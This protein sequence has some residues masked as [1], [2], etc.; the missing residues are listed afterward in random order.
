[1]WLAISISCYGIEHFRSSCNNYSTSIVE[2]AMI[3]LFKKIQQVPFEELFN[4]CENSK[5]KTKFLFLMNKAENELQ[6][7][8]ATVQF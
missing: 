7:V 3:V 2:I 4:G 8:D 1:M 6:L 5:L